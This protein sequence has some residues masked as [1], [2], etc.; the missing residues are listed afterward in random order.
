MSEQLLLGKL[1]PQRAMS[2]LGIADLVRWQCRQ[3]LSQEALL[4]GTGIA[5]ELLEDPNATI[6]TCQEMAFS[7]RLLALSGDSAF[8][9]EVGR[10]YRLSAFGHLGMLIPFAATRREGVELFIRYINLS[11]THFTPVLQLG[12][13]FG[14]LGLRGGE[15][16]GDLRRFYLDRDFAFVGTLGREILA[17]ASPSS[18]KALYLEYPEPTERRR[19]EDFFGAPVFFGAADSRLEFNSRALDEPMPQANPLALRLVEPE[20]ERRQAA[21][22]TANRQGWGQKVRQVLIA[23]EDNDYPGLERMATHFHCTSRTLRRY[24]KSEGLTYLTLVNEVRLAR[25]THLLCETGLPIASIA[26]LLGYSEAAVFSRAFSQWSG[27]AP[28]K[29]RRRTG[30]PTAI[31][32]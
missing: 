21:L 17:G 29:Y 5:A 25:A 28:L 11:Y 30:C 6:G 16:L 19:Y 31:V 4:A 2:V 12:D 10:Q 7:R 13:D 18:I 9:L 8:G 14:T 22:I 3:G 15:Y 1:D 27:M 26:M 24:L 23:I 32:P 20:C